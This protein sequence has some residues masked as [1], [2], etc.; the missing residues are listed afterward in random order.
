MYSTY[1]RLRVNIYASSRTVIR[2]AS[3]KL[4][5]KSRRDFVARDARHAFYR[6]MLQHHADA[7]RL[8]RQF[9]L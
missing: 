7:A 4:T 6:E 5:P 8:A 1:Q 2:A 3:R 9:R